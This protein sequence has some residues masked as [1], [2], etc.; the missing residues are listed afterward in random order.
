M[1]AVLF[2]ILPSVFQL[3]PPSPTH[4]ALPSGNNVPY[5]EAPLSLGGV[6]LPSL[7]NPIQIVH[8]SPSMDILADISE[9]QVPP[10]E[11]KDH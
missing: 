1:Y 7:T 11:Q 9:P 10:K 4:R 3:P 8:R 5:R 6:S 2:N